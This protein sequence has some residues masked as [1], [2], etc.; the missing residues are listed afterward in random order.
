LR[1]TN[2]LNLKFYGQK[3]RIFLRMSRNI[4]WPKSDSC[5]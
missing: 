5:S 2:T 4:S 1:K 3:W